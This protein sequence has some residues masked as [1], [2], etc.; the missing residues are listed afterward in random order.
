VPVP[1]FHLD[2]LDPDAGVVKRR[3]QDR[4]FLTW[5]PAAF[6]CLYPSDGPGWKNPDS[7]GMCQSTLS[8]PAARLAVPAGQQLVQGLRLDHA[9]FAP[10]GIQGVIRV[11]EP[12]VKLRSRHPASL[13][14]SAVSAPAD[15]P[16]PLPRSLRNV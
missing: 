11:G 5:T 1:E 16:A 14:R 15:F 4:S 2:F 13:G 10:V 12:V 7:R 6:D 8:R 3:E 9:R